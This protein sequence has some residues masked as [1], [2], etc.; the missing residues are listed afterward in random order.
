MAEPLM[1]KPLPPPLAAPRASSRA[2]S[3]V[4]DIESL[5]VRLPA[6]DAAE[7]RALGAEL[8]ARLA[9]EGPSLLSGARSMEVGELRLSLDLT[10]GGDIPGAASAAIVRALSRAVSSRTRSGEGR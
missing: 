10:R 7:G 8:A 9:A 3:P 4:L 1:P 6:R 5:R 2:R